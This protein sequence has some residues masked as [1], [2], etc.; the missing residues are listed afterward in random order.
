MIGL[1]IVLVAALV[2][3]RIAYQVG[4]IPVPV[5]LVVGPIVVIA[6]VFLGIARISSLR[7]LI[8]AGV[9]ATSAV[10]TAIS[11]PKGSILSGLLYTCLYALFIFCVPV[12]KAGQERFFR[13]IV[14]FIT[15]ISAIGIFQYLIQYVVKLPFLFT[16]RDIV[17]TSLL[18]EYNTLNELSAGSGIYKANGFFLL[19]ASALSQLA[20]RGLLI[21]IFILRDMRYVPILLLGMLFTFSG[22]G[23]ILFMIFGAVPLLIYIGKDPRYRLLLWVFP[24]VLPLAV[25]SMWDQFNLG[26]LFARTAEFSD[27]SSSGYARF[28]GNA[29]LFLIFSESDPLHFLF[30]AGPA[31]AEYYMRQAD[32]ESFA[33]GWIKLVTEYGIV[34]FAF[35]AT[36]FYTCAYQATRRHVLALAFLCHW[37][38]LDGNL[39][40]PQHLF[41][42]LA[43]CG[44]VQYNPAEA[45]AAR[46]K[47]PRADALPPLRPSPAE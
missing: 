39:L 1:R 36:F 42:A 12:D 27:A 21:A 17:P 3:Q 30:G 25:L 16:W 14:K 34:G 46:L 28:T 29:F 47:R 18:V 32:G 24:I 44:M 41:V 22:T 6:Q 31:M 4:S 11:D 23:I 45:A 7:L 26:L 9:A 38:V 35:F 15:F 10:S 43:M 20:S 8:F 5:V 37:L 13:A 19:E 40:V 33:S 2:F